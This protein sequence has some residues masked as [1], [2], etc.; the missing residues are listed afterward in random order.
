MMSDIA[1]I[2][3]TAPPPGQMPDDAAM[4]KIDGRESALRTM[5]M[6]TN[7]DNIASTT[8]VV[9]AAGA[10][11]VKRKIGSHLMFMGIGLIE[12]GPTWFEQL[13]AVGRQ[14]EPH[15]KHILV[16]DAARPAVAYTD[17]DLILS[18]TGQHDAVTEAVTLATKI[19]GIIVAGTIPGVCQP[20]Q[21]SFA[22]CL[23]PT[24]YSRA[25]FD[26]LC[27]TQKQP[28]NMKLIEGSS[29][30]VRCGTRDAGFVKAMLS[31]LPKPKIKPRSSPFE[32]AQW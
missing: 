23:T 7:R 25:T 4:M 14:L 10:E 17:L 1:V 22:E 26:T 12:A 3:V 13:Q 8:L 18:M 21:G 24:L 2:L 5:E 19:S 15:I 31:L 16:H 9:N 28:A 11:E 27:K 29:L 32:E 20:T 6:F 30:N